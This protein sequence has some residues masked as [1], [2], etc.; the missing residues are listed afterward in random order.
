MKKAYV[1]YLNGNDYT[2]MNVL[3]NTDLLLSGT[4]TR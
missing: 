3:Y 4:L 1:T 2:D